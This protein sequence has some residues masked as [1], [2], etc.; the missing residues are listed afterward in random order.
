MVVLACASFPLLTANAQVPEA[1][2]FQGQV[3][4]D[5]KPFNGN[6]TFK[7]AIVDDGTDNVATA[8][9][10]LN[11][12]EGGSITAITVTAGGSG[13]FRVPQVTIHDRRDGP[14]S[15]AE[16]KAK[17]QDGRVIE[18]IVTAPG[19]DYK[20]PMVMIESPP[21]ATIKTLWS[22][23]NSSIGG[24]EPDGK[25]GLT[26]N[27]GIFAVVLGDTGSGFMD[28][29]P[30]EV[31]ATSPV[32][33]RVWFN[34]GGEFEQLAPDQLVTSTPYAMH[35]KFAGTATSALVAEMA[36][37]AES[38]ADGAVSFDQVDPSIALWSRDVATDAIEYLVA[39]QGIRVEPFTDINV[40]LEFWSP[41][42]TM[43]NGANEASAPGA[44]VSGGGSATSPNL[45]GGSH[46]T[47]SGGEGNTASGSRSTVGGGEG[48]TASNFY[49]TVAGGNSNAASGSRSTVGGGS[50]NTASNFYSTVAG[51]NNNTASG[52]RS[53]VGGGLENIADEQLST[54]GGGS[55]NTASEPF[56]TVAGGAGNTAS[57]FYSTVA[58]GDGN[59]ASSSSSTVGGGRGNTASGSRST[60]GGGSDNTAS[61][62]RS[63]VPGGLL[64]QAAGDYSLAAGRRAKVKDGHHGTFV[65]ADS[66]NWNFES[67]GENQFIIRANGGV[68]IGT[69][70]PQ[71]TLHVNGTTRT[72]VLQITGA[73]LAEQ[74]PF[75]EQA[76]PG[77]V[78]AIDPNSP[79]LLRIS[80]VKYNRRVAGI[81]AGANDFKTGVL[82][83]HESGNEFGNPVALSGRVYVNCD[84]T[85]HAIE[86]GDMLTTADLPGYARK[87]T[88]FQ[89]AQGAIIGKAM[90]G[91]AKG[92]QGMILVL[93][94][95][96]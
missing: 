45:A 18:I 17:M 26:V 85:D 20:D 77:M 78:V 88:D 50:N 14:G 40:S 32:Y 83:G 9:A 33:L 69:S 82:L 12:R 53:T 39:N 52:F 30:A 79:G 58:G 96:Q 25:V 51:G 41:M 61:G 22:N 55:R 28:V 16:A 3:T 5:D 72:N 44:T 95:L 6:G 37:S 56:S 29:L 36:Q 48:N 74:F 76:E 42:I 24:S 87:A 90:E 8:T 65:W 86:P 13:Y 71:Q 70:N 21:E 60:V 46:S 10:T 84:A 59:T 34:G 94:N 73:D 80:R 49:S 64:N 63:T 38:V 92:G 4:V 91:L 35:A 7:F 93:V 15:G 31:F 19:S 43:G 68:G 47:V 89:R 54:V 62:S 11:S 23:D 67:T 66:T 1:I 2:H 75:S 57:N 27:N 81:V